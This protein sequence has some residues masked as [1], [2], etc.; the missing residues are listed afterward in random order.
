MY[1]G[2]TPYP[3]DKQIEK[4]DAK[5]AQTIERD[6]IDISEADKA[7]LA[8]YGGY[9]A[10]HDLSNFVSQIKIHKSGWS[11][12]DAELLTRFEMQSHV[13]D[14]LVTNYSMLQYMLIRSI[15]NGIWSGTSKWLSEN[16][17]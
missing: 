6:L 8:D 3:G 7:K 13:P 11:P 15:E 5:Y 2:R 12:D 16:P 14:I 17:S 1:T 10:K 4:R 9:P